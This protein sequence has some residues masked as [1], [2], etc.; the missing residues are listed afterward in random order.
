MNNRWLAVAVL[1]LLVL[2]SAVV[3]KNT[4][5]TVSANGPVPPTPWMLAN[6]PVP[7]TPWVAK[8]GPVPPTPWKNGPVPP[9]PWNK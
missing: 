9:T 1:V 7:P 8:N 3:L 5:N 2:V 4:V 6:G